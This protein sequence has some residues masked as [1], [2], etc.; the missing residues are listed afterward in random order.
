VNNMYFWNPFQ[1]VQFNLLLATMYVS[2]SNECQIYTIK[3]RLYKGE[4]AIG[5]T[6]EMNS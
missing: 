1:L 5:N 3:K 2:R 6:S 4:K